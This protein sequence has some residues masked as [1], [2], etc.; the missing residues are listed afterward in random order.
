MMD[1][2]FNII[3][4]LI[5]ELISTLFGAVLTHCMHIKKIQIPDIG[6]LDL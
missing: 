4:G 6:T 3:E 5:T 1:S 2:F